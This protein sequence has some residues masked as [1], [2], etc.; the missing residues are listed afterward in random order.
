VDTTLD[1]SNEPGTAGSETIAELR[2]AA[3]DNLTHEKRVQAV[4]ATFRNILLVVFLIFIFAVVQTVILWHVCN[5]GMKTATSLEHEGLPT[6][7][8]L[9]SLQEHLA[10]Y[11]LDSYEYLFATEGERAAKAKAAQTMANQ[12][13]AE[14]TN[15][16]KFLPESGGQVLA[17]NLEV[18]VDDLNTEFEKVRNMV[19]SDFAA[20]MKEM[21]RN[22]PTR[23][24]KVAVAAAA[25][26]DYGYD[27]SGRQASAT[28]GSFGW[29]KNY[30]AIFG[31]ANILVAFGAVMFVLLAA[32]RSSA[33]LSETLARLDGRTRE[34]QQANDAL[35]TEV[36]EHQRAEDTLRESEER[37]SGAFEHA[38]I[39]VALVSTDGRMIKVN[40][41]LC[42]LFGYSEADLLARTFEDITNPKDREASA[43]NLRRLIAG[44]VRSFQI[45]KRYVHAR[46][47]LITALSNMSL[48][49]D[50][51]HHPLYLIAQIEDIS[52]RK[53]AEAELE[54][55]HQRLLDVSRQAGMA[56]VATSV[57]HNVGN[58][59]NSVNVSAMFV[60]DGM[61]QSECATLGKVAAMLEEN[62][63]NL[64]D[65]ITNDK[66]GKH[67]PG[68]IR[69]LSETLLQERD[70]TVKELSSL[71]KHID[72]IKEIVAKQQ[73][74][75]KISG[76]SQVV[77]V[78]E[79]VEDS[80]HINAAALT[81]HE[82]ELIRDYHEVPPI[83]IDKHKV[84]QI[85]VNLI[86]N[87]KYACDDGGP[88]IKQLTV[89]VAKAEGCIKIFVIDNGI[90]IPPENL[91]R[92]FSHG[93]TTRKDGHGFG[94][95]SGSLAA[96]ELGGSL[97]AQSDGLGTGATFTL[98]L[99]LSPR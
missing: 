26:K 19:D 61:R 38:P 87:A 69:L 71:C 92:I 44:E 98:E 6:L 94:L 5:T 39:G 43:E 17:S 30:A 72:H 10:L 9:A 59:L 74:Y 12:I 93:F 77:E 57:L 86:R 79:L 37:F 78:A 63:A 49:R 60:I 31:A 23:T 35:Q 56:E 68:F 47:D 64:G 80:L 15:I 7:N 45:E 3:T 55:A 62:S 51:H 25:L 20:A 29:I 83:N 70:T 42:D 21:D 66:K 14:L 73:S 8:T 76:V 46:G 95:H 91:T 53:R 81:R 34:L 1:T 36:V 11:R 85:L 54:D 82:V 90:G 32:R 89:R 33:Q 28:F 88:A 27:L 24:Q 97:I 22:I 99:P 48:V 2:P 96:K 4:S 13:R 16:Q 58:V 84:L 65:F 52:E 67:L 41:A 50:A 18:A 75:A 40:R